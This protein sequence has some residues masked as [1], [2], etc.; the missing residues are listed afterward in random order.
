MLFVIILSFKKA[1]NSSAPNF[2]IKGDDNVVAKTKNGVLS[3]SSIH[4]K[5]RILKNIRKT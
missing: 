4:I 1:R 3:F 2:N 5:H